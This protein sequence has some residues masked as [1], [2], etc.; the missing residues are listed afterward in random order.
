MLPGK[1]KLRWPEV[2]SGGCRRGSG[3]HL[4]WEQTGIIWVG[5]KVG[6]QILG[7][8][9]SNFERI[10][11]LNNVVFPLSVKKSVSVDLPYV[12]SFACT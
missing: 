12:K 9:F 11:F 4:L 6:F 10:F 7:F 5:L 1:G 2:G 8:G 3:G